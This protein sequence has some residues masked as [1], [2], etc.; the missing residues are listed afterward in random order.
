MEHEL[1]GNGHAYVSFGDRDTQELRIETATELLTL[2]CKEQPHLF[3]S[4]LA[5]VLTGAAPKGPRGQ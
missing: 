1:N 5:R 2:W 4:Y 3:G